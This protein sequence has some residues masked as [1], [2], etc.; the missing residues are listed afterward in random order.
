MKFRGT[1]FL[2][3]FRK[4][5]AKKKRF[6]LFLRILLYFFTVIALTSLILLGISFW[7]IQGT[8]NLAQAGKSNLELAERE[9]VKLDF[10]KVN[11]YLSEAELNFEEA[12]V[13]F[14]FVSFFKK[15]PWVKNQ[16][17]AVSYLLAAGSE[18]AK[19]LRA[20]SE[21]MSEIFEIIGETGAMVEGIIVP[22]ET[23]FV[24]ISSAQKKEILEKLFLASPRLNDAIIKINS[25]IESLEKINKAGVASQIMEVVESARV[26]LIEIQNKISQIA[27]LAEILPQLAGYPEAKTYLFLLQNSDEMRPTGGF[28]GTYG[29]IKV[30]DG[31]INFFETENIYVLDGPAEKFLKVEPPAPIKKYLKVSN[32]FMRDS[33]WSPD[34]PD[35]AARA[36]W[37][38][39][40]ERGPEEKIDLVVAVTPTFVENLLRKIG[41]IELNGEIFT[42]ENL[43]DVLQY[44]VEK[45]YYE[46]GISEIQRKDI[47]GDLTDKI[48]K[49]LI[50]LPASR[51]PDILA[52]VKNSLEEKH[53]LF[54]GKNLELQNFILKE[55]WAGEI[56]NF[57]G[58]YLMVIDANLASLKTDS[59]MDKRIR[60]SFKTGSDGKLHARVD[61][62]YKNNGTFTWKT[63]RYRTYTRIYVPD[64]SILIKG[65]GMMENDKISDPARRPGKVDVSKEFG[66][67]YF[68]AFI[69]VEPGE[70]RTLSFEYI[71]P[72]KIKNQINSG[73]YKLFVQKQAGTKGHSLT[74]NLNFDK[75]IK[76]ALPAEE[77]IEWGNE[78]Y[79]LQTDLKIDREIE[80]GF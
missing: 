35:S 5:K 29:I 51:W 39:H 14:R 8:Y 18:T 2:D 65:I 25:A 37:F 74:L 21:L 26:A 63:T 78:I 3:I 66:K 57:D 41:N 1:N 33:N 40:A 79:K 20:V 50:T 23:T 17:E 28:I 75:K 11:F 32:W 68:G 76:R 6:F 19:G 56:K 77:A 30:R 13:R 53:L 69:S 9:V 34:F 64:G 61:I 44:K 60:Y 15:V 52:V 71:L 46:K 4:E 73:M 12:Q 10:K 24:E 43:M 54:W 7:F 67:T 27:P 49:R 47:L 70:E 36:E 58:D 31:E 22:E 59:V 45:E 62:T 48:F 55:G 38:Y 72:D 42:P 16:F 80:V